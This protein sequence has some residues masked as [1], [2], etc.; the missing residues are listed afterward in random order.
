MNSDFLKTLDALDNA[1]SSRREALRTAGR[2]GGAAALAVTPLYAMARESYAA[3]RSLSAAYGPQAHDVLN[4]ALT[5]EYLEYFFYLRAVGNADLM[6]PKGEEV[7]AEADIPADVLP[8]FQE[9]RNNE[10]AHV[11]AL[12]TVI[13]DLED[14]PGEPVIYE[15]RD[16]TYEVDGTDV[17]SDYQLFLTLAQG[18]EDT[19]VRA[20]KGQAP[21]LQGTP[22]L[23]TAL[24]IHSVEARHAAAVRRVRGQTIGKD[25]QG[26]IPFDQPDA[27]DAIEA[28]YADSING[29]P[30]PSE[31]NTTQG[32]VELVAA[33]MG[34]GYSEE[35]ITE[36]FDEP[37]DMDSVNAIAGP[38]ITGEPNDGGETP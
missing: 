4:Y 14:P 26:W 31:A 35:E 10:L 24:Q 15:M 20:Y 17:F 22:Y 1:P 11:R 19:G 37:L 23:T 30:F 8:L 38:F 34:R 6:P 36:A 3:K 18:F 7:E 32:G 13:E 29:G 5:L 16:F 12:T 9:I 33:L 25:I 27:P 2:L 28:V 21:A